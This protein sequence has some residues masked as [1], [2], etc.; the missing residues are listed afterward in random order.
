[1]MINGITMNTEARNNDLLLII[2]CCQYSVHPSDTKCK[3]SIGEKHTLLS[4]QRTIGTKGGILKYLQV[5]KGH[6]TL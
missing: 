1:M 5:A 3:K 6:Q 2:K 4:K